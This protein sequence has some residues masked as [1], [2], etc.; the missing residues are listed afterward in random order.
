[1]YIPGEL[2]SSGWLPFETKHARPKAELTTGDLV[3]RLGFLCCP[4]NLTVFT[5][6]VNTHRYAVSATDGV[7]FLWQLLK[8]I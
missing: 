7:H 2:V 1:M 3:S 5:A 4:K 6:I 8:G